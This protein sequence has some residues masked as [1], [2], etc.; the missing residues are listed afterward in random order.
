M[1]VWLF[2]K[3]HVVEHRNK[4]YACSKATLER[5]CE[6]WLAKEREAPALGKSKTNDAM[7][8]NS[9]QKDSVVDMMI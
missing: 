7:G 2:D 9:Y 3:K 1:P 5:Q 6:T 4:T 8:K